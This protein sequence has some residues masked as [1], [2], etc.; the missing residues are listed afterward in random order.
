MAWTVET[1]N[2]TVD[3]TQKT[4]NS[5]IDLALRRAKELEI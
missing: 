2:Q 1:L 5:E 4:P 3:A